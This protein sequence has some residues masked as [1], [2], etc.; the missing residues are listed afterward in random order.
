MR[1]WGLAAAMLLAVAA[2]NSDSDVDPTLQPLPK[3]TT[4][5]RYELIQNSG[6]VVVV[7]LASVEKRGWF[8][9]AMA[10]GR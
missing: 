6:P 7:M 10:G 3:V 8:H 1:R 2:C 9:H 5:P 4:L